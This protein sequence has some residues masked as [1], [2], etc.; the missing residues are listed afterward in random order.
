MFLLSLIFFFSFFFSIEKKKKNLNQN[1]RTSFK[2]LEEFFALPEMPTKNFG[3]QS[4]AYGSL[5]IEN[6]SFDWTQV[7]F[8]F[9]FCFSIN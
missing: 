4:L 8:N 7:Y 6:G 1:Y 2:K 3:D 9:I 5:K